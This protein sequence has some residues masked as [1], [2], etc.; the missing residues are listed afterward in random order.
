MIG[1]IKVVYLTRSIGDLSSLQDSEVDGEVE[2]FTRRSAS[3][4]IDILARYSI[5]L[6]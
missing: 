4:T 1:M 5:T 6:S 2:S 3:K